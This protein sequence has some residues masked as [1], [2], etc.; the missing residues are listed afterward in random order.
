MYLHKVQ[1]SENLPSFSLIEE[2]T[3][4]G[5]P[6]I[7]IVFPDGSSD[8]LVLNKYEDMEGHFIGHLKNETDA[9]VAMVNHP[10]HAE[11]TI[12]SNRVIGSTMY[13][14][15]NNGNVEL[16]P[17]VFSNELEQDEV[18]ERNTIEDDEPIVNQAEEDEEDE[19]ENL[20]TATKAKSVPK[21][22]KLQ[23]KV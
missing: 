13:K 2:R 4:N 19:V 8:N 7:E 22:A 20:L 11:L 16:I 3:F 21:T 15:H 12:L 18:M 6:L 17:E 10:E 9:C 23:I 1:I 5:S 14:W